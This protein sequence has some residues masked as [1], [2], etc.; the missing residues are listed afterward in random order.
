MD[1]RGLVTEFC[2]RTGLPK[3]PQ[4]QGSKDAQVAQIVALLNELS[5]E[6]VSRNIW[7]FLTREAVFVSVNTEDQGAL[8]DIAPFGFVSMLQNTI[9]DRTNRLM[10]IGPIEPHN[11]QYLKASSQTGPVSS[12]RINNGR[13]FLYP[14][15]PAGHTYAFE[16]RS[17]FS[18][19]DQ[20]GSVYRDQFQLDKDKSLF[21]DA[22]LL[23]GLRWKWKA[24]KGLGYAEDFRRYEEMLANAC[25]RDG[26]KPALSLSQNASGMP[27]VIVPPGN[28]LQ[29]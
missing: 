24:E 19:F 13:L 3:P 26:T 20:T 10:T 14:A 9:F 15:P 25:A 16:Y 8:S 17:S 21:S 11:W 6:L 23:A 22:I 29:P 5:E 1:L 12:Y 27:Y 4:I 28:W 2:A 7:S 18:V